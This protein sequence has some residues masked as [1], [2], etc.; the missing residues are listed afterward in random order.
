MRRTMTLLACLA[1]CSFGVSAAFA[2]GPG[3]SGA[4]TETASAKGATCSSRAM[5]SCSAPDAF[6]AMVRMVGDKAVDCPA[7]AEKMAKESNAKIVFAV[8]GNKYDNEQSAW[9][10]LADSSEMFVKKF[11]AITCVMDGKSYI[12]CD[13]GAKGCGSKAAATCGKDGEAKTAAATCDKSAKVQMASATCDKSG[14]AKTASATCCKTGQAVKDSPACCKSGDAKTAAATCDKSK[15]PATC[16]KGDTKT[17][18][19]AGSCQ[20][21]GD[22]KMVKADGDAKG[23]GCG[24]GCVSKTGDGKDCCPSGAKTVAATSGCGSKAADAKMAGCCEMGGEKLVIIDA[25]A[26]AEMCQNAKD[27][28]FMVAGQSYDSWDAAVKARDE[29]VGVVKQVK[30]SYLVDGKTVDCSSKICPEDMKAGKVK[31]VVADKQMEC[32]TM[33]RVELAKAQYEAAKQ[34]ATKTVATRM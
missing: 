6:P 14:E 13:E 24:K 16:T 23:E 7:S 15:A 12:V 21:K 30:M 18:S 32:E 20:T 17:A 25:K 5:A 26:C 22:A 34:Y 10:A 28:K 31:F 4:K 3:C 9:A 19:A 1:A 27:K 8:A 2:G 29:L 11:T 33:A